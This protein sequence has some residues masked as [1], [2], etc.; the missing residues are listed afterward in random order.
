MAKVPGPCSILGTSVEPGSFAAKLEHFSSSSPLFMSPNSPILADFKT[1]SAPS[2]SSIS[3]PCSGLRWLVSSHSAVS[4]LSFLWHSSA[5]LSAAFSNMSSIWM[6]PST[7]DSVFS[8]PSLKSPCAAS[9]TAF[10]FSY[11]TSSFD[12]SCTR[13]SLTDLASRLFSAALSTSPNPALLHLS[14]TSSD[15]S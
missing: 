13:A 8:K 12:F 3:L 15:L 1:F 7:H 5:L 2:L 10:R 9:C 14:P 4:L 6:D 11:A